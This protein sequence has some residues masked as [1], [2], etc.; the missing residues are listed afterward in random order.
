MHQLPPEDVAAAC[1]KETQTR[2]TKRTNTERTNAA[3][4][5]AKKGGVIVE[6]QKLSN[7]RLNRVQTCVFLPKGVQIC[8]DEDLVDNLVNEGVRAIFADAKLVEGDNIA[9][10]VSAESLV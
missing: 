9:D 7:R 8:Y 4:F 2:S 3:I 5:N 6:L 1:E 10:A